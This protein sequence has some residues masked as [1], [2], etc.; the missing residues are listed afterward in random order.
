MCVQ[1][2]LSELAILYEQCEGFV[3]DFV[4]RTFLVDLIVL[5]F[6]G[7]S[8]IL[9]MDWLR[10][11]HVVLDCAERTINSYRYPRFTPFLLYISR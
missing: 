10:A 2:P 7:F 8:I 3:L 4:T 5:G 11:N 6:E 9:G 1:T